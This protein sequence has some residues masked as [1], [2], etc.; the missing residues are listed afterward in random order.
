MII[1]NRP[2]TTG[3][4]I[5]VPP[6]TGESSLVSSMEFDAPNDSAPESQSFELLPL[7]DDVPLLVSD[8]EEE[9]EHENQVETT[10]NVTEQ[11][12]VAATSEI[13]SDAP[14]L[15]SPQQQRSQVMAVIVRYVAAKIKNWFPPEQASRI[16]GSLPLDKFLLILTS[17]LQVTLVEF[18][19]S[20]IYLFR[21]MDIVYLLRYLNQSNNMA[22]YNGMD[23][24]LRRLIVGCFKLALTRGGAT[25]DFAHIT[26]LSNH[27]IGVVTRKIILR[28]NGKVA[29]KDREL[30]RM[31][32]ELY[33]FVRMVAVVH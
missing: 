24:S 14:P 4:P 5:Y 6:K 1:G 33:K 16:D 17:R 7:A 26:G 27:E 29:I 20:V 28:M 9:H 3:F 30:L 11:T 22:N 2:E 15:P 23:F 31:K 12:E 25:R 8:S 18:T 10:E 32:L 13:A 21:Y 19:R